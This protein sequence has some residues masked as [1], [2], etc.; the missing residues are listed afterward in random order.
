MDNLE[1]D[2]LFSEEITKYP[3]ES[4]SKICHVIMGDINRPEDGY[5]NRNLCPFKSPPNNCAAL[6]YEYLSKRI[7]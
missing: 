3:H 1:I 4:Y 6:F 2:K 7:E 5:C